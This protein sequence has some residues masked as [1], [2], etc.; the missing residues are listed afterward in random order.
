M[1]DDFLTVVM[2]RVNNMVFEALKV[3]SPSIG[4]EWGSAFGQFR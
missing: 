1:N 3:Q 2:D 4:V